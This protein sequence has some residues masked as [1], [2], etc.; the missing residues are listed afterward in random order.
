MKTTN[1]NAKAN[2]NECVDDEMCFT[3]T[4]KSREC[5]QRS[6]NKR[7]RKK[8][9]KI[10]RTVINLNEIVNLLNTIPLRIGTQNIRLIA[11]GRAR[12][13]LPAVD[14]PLTEA[15]EH[16]TKFSERYG[17]GIIGSSEM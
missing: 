8:E 16:S 13:A 5:G 11:K 3:N 9:K 1:G 12:N 14:I 2:V 17:I 10:Q 7:T 15:F 6:C 4:A